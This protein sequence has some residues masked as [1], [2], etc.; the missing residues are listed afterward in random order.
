DEDTGERTLDRRK[1]P[2]DIA[3]RDVKPVGRYGLSLRFSDGHDTGIYTFSRL[4]TLDES[5][6]EQ[7][8]FDV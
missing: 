3:I 5:G 1:V 2:L 6:A 8:G 7:A 4:H